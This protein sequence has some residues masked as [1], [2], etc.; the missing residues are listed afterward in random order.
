MLTY[1]LE[2]L[3]V[4]HT[5]CLQLQCWVGEG[6][7]RGSLSGDQELEECEVFV[8]SVHLR[9]RPLLHQSGT[10]G[11]LQKYIFKKRMQGYNTAG[12][13][14]CRDRVPHGYAEHPCN[15]IIGLYW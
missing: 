7:G 8:C 11:A 13:R 2:L 6:E 4:V 1:W 15:S 14:Y 5:R 12:I 3:L 10:E 9:P